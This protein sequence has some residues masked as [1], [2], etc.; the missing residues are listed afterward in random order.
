MPED[1]TLCIYTGRFSKDKNPLL[2]AE[3]VSELD[4]TGHPFR[5]LFIG[6]G[7]QTSEIQSYKT[8]GT[9]L[10]VPFSDLPKY[11]RAADIGVWPMQES[12]SMLDALS[13]GIPIVVSDKMGDAE[14]TEGSGAVY[15][16]GDPKDLA[17]VLAGLESKETRRHLGEVA[18]TKAVEKHSWIGIAKDLIEEYESF[19]QR[20][21]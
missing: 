21:N 2:L 4:G 11:Y 15:R 20:A 3:A 6:D 17:R 16:E 14:R 12:L 10:Y 1:A 9:I 19:L 18:R 13:C 5:A 8:S 7:V